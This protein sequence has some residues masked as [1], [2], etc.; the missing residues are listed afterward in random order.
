MTDLTKSQLNTILSALDGKPRNPNTK[1]AALKAIANHGDRLGLTIDDILAAAGGLLDGRMGAEAFRASLQETE[2]PAEEPIEPEAEAINAQ[3]KAPKLRNGT[4]Q[5]LMIELLRRPE[6]ATVDQIA[7]AMGWARHTVRGAMAGALKKKFGLI[8]TSE[9]TK[10]AAR[11]Y[12]IA[13]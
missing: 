5:A 10:G 2:Q 7:E 4:K 11:V 12:R 3:P 13:G 1:D 9:K 6:G 8:I